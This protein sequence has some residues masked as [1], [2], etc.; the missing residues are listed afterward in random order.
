MVPHTSDGRV[1]FAIPWHDHTL[2]GTTDTPVAEAPLEPV[3]MDQEIEFILSTAS[4]YLAR[5]PTRADILSVFAGI[6]PLVK[7]GRAGRT[8]RAVARSHHPHRSLRP[9]Y[10]LR[11]QMDHLSPHGGGLRQP[12]RHAGSLAGEALRYRIFESARLSTRPRRNSARCA[13]MAPTPR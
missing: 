1:M 3:A 4:L 8:A 10:H 11:R 6:R 13:S 9:A 5:K 12:G 7:S 2:I